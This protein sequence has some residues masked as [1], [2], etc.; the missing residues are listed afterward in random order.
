[1]QTRE[2][3]TIIATGVANTASVCAAF[4]RLSAQAELSEDLEQIR[5]A[6]R[7]VL[8]GVGAFE[9]GMTRLKQM[10]LVEVLRERILV[11]RRATLAIC[12]GLQLLCEQSEESPGVE[13]LGV[14]PLSVRRFRSTNVRVPQLGWNFVGA[15]AGCGLLQDGYAYYANSYYLEKIP[16]GWHGALSHHGHDFVAAIEHPNRQILAT[17]LHPELSGA[18]GQSL[19]KRWLDETSC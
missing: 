16:A 15:Q 17:Q 6:Q 18:W 8:P 5:R 1:M 7:L 3:V 11:E 9:A 14:L 2:R 10:G 12:L 19:L 4:E 13:G